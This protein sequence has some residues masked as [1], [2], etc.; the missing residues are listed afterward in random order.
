MSTAPRIQTH[1]AC[2]RCGYDLVG[3]KFDQACPE[4]GLLISASASRGDLQYAATWW[5]RS[6]RT[7]LTLLLASLGSLAAMWVLLFVL[8]LA[9]INVRGE[10]TVADA[11]FRPVL[12]SYT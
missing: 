2:G 10:A 1:L 8:V 3:L 6:L 7:G 4:C 9:E 5:L 11:L 12:V